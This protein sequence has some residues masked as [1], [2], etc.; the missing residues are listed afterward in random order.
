MKWPTTFQALL[1]RRTKVDKSVH[2][3]T[4]SLSSWTYN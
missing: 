3:I 2:F 1:L 4:F